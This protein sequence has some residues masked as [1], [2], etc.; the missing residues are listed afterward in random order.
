MIAPR[1]VALLWRNRR[2]LSL[3]FVEI[4]DDEREIKIRT[5]ATRQQI[6]VECSRIMFLIFLIDDFEIH[7][8][9]CSNEHHPK[10]WQN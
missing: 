8:R 2:N 5:Y 3:F 9:G 4:V 1:K 6:Q 7:T 10:I